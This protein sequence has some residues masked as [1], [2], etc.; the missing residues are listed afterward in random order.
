ML[1]RTCT[2]SLSHSW[3]Y[4]VFPQW[5]APEKSSCVTTVAVCCLCLCAT[6][7]QTAT[8]KQMRQTAAINTE[9]RSH[10]RGS[11]CTLPL[12]NPITL[13]QN[14]VGRRPGHLVTCRVQTTPGII[15]TSRYIKHITLQRTHI[16]LVWLLIPVFP[17]T[18]SHQ[19][20]M[21][22][23]SVEEGH[24]ITLSF[25][26][27]SLETQDVCEFDYV[28]VHDSADTGAGRVLGRWGLNKPHNGFNNPLLNV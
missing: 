9:V 2:H 23:L 25:R 11:H 26:N 4:C 13:L 17:L 10:R 18:G 3:N 14:V 12:S 22:Y 27:F 6:V 19:L 16:K 20:C 21:W 8:T 7:I 24:V 15:L 28:E 5:A 1:W